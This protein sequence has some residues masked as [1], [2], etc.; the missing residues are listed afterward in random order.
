MQG[1]WHFQAQKIDH[2]RFLTTRWRE[3]G[4]PYS[5]AKVRSYKVS[6]STNIPL[7]AFPEVPLCQYAGFLSQHLSNIN[8]VSM[9]T[10]AANTFEPVSSSLCHVLQLQLKNVFQGAFPMQ[11][12]QLC[13]WPVPMSPT[14]EVPVTSLCW[15]CRSALSNYPTSPFTGRTSAASSRGTWL[16]SPWW[17]LWSMLV[18]ISQP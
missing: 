7:H 14:L 17:W 1:T 8:V 11:V 18:R 6:P 15:T 5:T 2:T 10:T 3:L 9:V 13:P 12:Q 16:S 4:G